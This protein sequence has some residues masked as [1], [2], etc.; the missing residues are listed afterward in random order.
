MVKVGD[1]VVINH[2]L[3]EGCTGRVTDFGHDAGLLLAKVV[4]FDK[5]DLIEKQ[6]FFQETN[7]K[8]IQ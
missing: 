7:L 3:F 8:V 5:S 2:P 1:K 6:V 4:F